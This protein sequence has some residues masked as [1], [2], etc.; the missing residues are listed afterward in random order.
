M[1][2]PSFFSGWGVRT[3]ATSEARY[4]PM[5]YHN[6][7]I[8]PHDNAMITAGFARYGFRDHIQPIF[9]GLLGA[10][11]EMDQ[12]RLPELFCGFR[13]RPGRAPILYP[14]ACAPQAWASGA[15]LHILSALLGLKIDAASRT[16]I[17]SSP[18]LPESVGTVSVRDLRVGGGSAD[19]VLRNNGGTVIADV[20]N[21]RG[22]AKVIMA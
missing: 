12:R 17:L 11:L 15:M 13:R 16:I 7:S 21:S 19:F 5:A 14:V 6:G 20:T 1:L 8:W 9:D 10:A 2:T 4:N 3:I 18:R 22:G